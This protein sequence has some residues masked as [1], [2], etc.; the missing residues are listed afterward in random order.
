MLVDV[1]TGRILQCKCDRTIR[2]HPTEEA[3]NS[4]IMERSLARAAVWWP[5][6]LVADSTGLTTNGA[7]VRIGLKQEAGVVFIETKLK[8]I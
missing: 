3:E 5:D 2:L 1:A 6:D 4:R 7:L 8:L